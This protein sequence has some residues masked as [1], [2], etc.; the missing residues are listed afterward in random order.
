MSANIHQYAGRKDAWHQLGVVL[1]KHFN[2]DDLVRENILQFDVFKSQLKDGLGRPVEAWGTFRWDKDKQ[3]DPNAAEF[4]GV[5]GK[6][7]AI[8]P[9]RNGFHLID[10]LIGAQNGAH[11]ET[12]G[13]LGKGEVVWALADLN[14]GF[15]IGDDR[16]DSFLLFYTSYDGS[17]KHTYRLTN[18]RVVCQNTLSAA[19]S[20]KTAAQ[21]AI[22]HTKNAMPRVIE[23]HKALGSLAADV[24]TV[25]E[26]LRFLAGKR[27]TRES[28]TALFDRLFPK[29]DA[30]TDTGVVQ[31]SSTRRDNIIAAILEKYELNDGNAFPEQRGTAYNLLNAVTNWVDHDRGSE[32]SKRALSATFGTGDAMKSDALGFLLKV[33]QTLP[34][35]ASAPIVSLGSTAAPTATAVMD[36]SD[37]PLGASDVELDPDASEFINDVV[38]RTLEL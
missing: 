7:Y 35:A 11:Y 14:L 20:S 32:T 2:W 27:I 3:P 31:V 12:A 5:V 9:H 38:R 29:K 33:G 36:A 15:N 13:A 10:A 1:G 24:K 8:V 26:K 16:T 23:A 21:F 18:T 19:I 17:Y 4:L 28:A 34:D 37:D 30:T 25:E 22:R 6:D